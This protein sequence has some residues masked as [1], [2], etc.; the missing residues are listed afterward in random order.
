MAEL[1]WVFSS[2]QGQAINHYPSSRKCEAI[3][4][5]RTEDLHERIENKLQLSEQE[6]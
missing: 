3:G 1:G 6:D 5:Q 2:E 4:Y